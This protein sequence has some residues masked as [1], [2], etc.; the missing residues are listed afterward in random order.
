MKIRFSVYKVL[1]HGPLLC[2]KSET[3]MGAGG[4]SLAHVPAMLEF[5]VCYEV[6]YLRDVLCRTWHWRLADTML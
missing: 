5:Q 1:C 2:C 4:P 3:P 6:L